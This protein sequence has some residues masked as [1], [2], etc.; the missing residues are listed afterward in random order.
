MKNQTKLL[1]ALALLLG[2]VTRLNALWS[3]WI[4]LLLMIFAGIPHGSYD[5]RVAEAKWKNGIISQKKVVL[6]YLFSGFTMASIFLLSPT[7]GFIVFILISFYHFVDGE[8]SLDYLPWR[9][10]LFGLSAIILP[11]GLH[12]QSASVYMKFFLDSAAIDWLSPVIQIVAI[13]FTVLICLTL[14]LELALWKLKVGTNWIELFVCLLGWVLL[15]PLAGFCVWFIGRHS[16]E[17][18]ALCKTLFK[19]NKV[20]LPLDFIALSLLAFCLLLPLSLLF[21]LTD[22]SQLFTASI[23]LVAGLT[24]PHVLVTHNL[25]QVLALSP[26]GTK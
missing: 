23:I 7:I 8:I 18:I 5:L 17:H 25:R 9:A 22:L 11:I 13:C 20:S 15:P 19:N 21:D 24:L 1:I 12:F 4:A 16:S 2:I 14:I 26:G 10:A 3:E 6:I